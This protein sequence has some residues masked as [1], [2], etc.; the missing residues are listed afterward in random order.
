[1]DRGCTKGD[2]DS[3]II[4]NIIVDAVLRTWKE[5]DYNSTLALFYADDGLLEN[6]NPEELQ[7][8][9]DQIIKIF[10]K[11]GLRTNESETK[12]MVF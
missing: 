6:N 7:E 10:E 1:M 12:Y 2:T 11:V 8:D 5:G 4:L 3:P 9:L